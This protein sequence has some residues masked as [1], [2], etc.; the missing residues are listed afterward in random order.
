MAYINGNY[1]PGYKFVYM[2]TSQVEV[3]DIL[4]PETSSVSFLYNAY[5]N[6]FRSGESVS[7]KTVIAARETGSL[8]IFNLRGQCLAKFELVSGIQQTTFSSKD[9]PSGVYL[10]QLRTNKATET[11]KLILLK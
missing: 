1:T 11:K 5:P 9:L 7:I 3:E 2:H 6:P 4:V 10:Y 8:T